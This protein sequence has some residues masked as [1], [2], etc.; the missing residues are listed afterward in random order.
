MG[1]M[2]DLL[3]RMSFR[4]WQDFSSFSGILR[5][6]VGAQCIEH[7]VVQLNIESTG[8]SGFNSR[9]EL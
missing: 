8:I 7:F 5:M 1:S 6:T 9:W 4:L 2:L 3:F